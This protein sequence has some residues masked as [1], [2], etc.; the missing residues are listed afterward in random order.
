MVIDAYI[1]SSIKIAVK[2][3]KSINQAC[4]VTTRQLFTYKNPKFLENEKWGYSN[5]NTPPH[6]FSFEIKDDYIHIGRGG[7][8]K[9]EKHLKKFSVTLNI[10]DNTFVGPHIAFNQSKVILRP[11]QEKWLNEFLKYQ[12]GCGQAYTS[13]GKCHSAGTKIVMY[14][15]TTKNVEDIQVGDRLM[16]IDS[17][18]RTVQDTCIGKGEMYEIAPYKSKPFKVNKD[19]ILSLEV[20]RNSRHLSRSTKWTEG[21]IVEY[22]VG[23]YLELSQGMKKMLRLRMVGVEFKEVPIPFDPYFIGLWLGDG[24]KRSTSIANNNEKEIVRY[25]EHFAKSNKLD[26]RVEKNKDKCTIYHLN[27]GGN[28]G[29]RNPLRA[30]LLNKC[31]KEGE[32]TI[33]EEYLIN[34]RKNRLALLAGFLDADGHLVTSDNR[35]FEVTIKKSH[36]VEKIAYLSRSLGFT[37]TE[38]ICKSAYTKNGV[39]VKTGTHTRLFITGK[40]F[41]IP[42]KLKRKRA[43]TKLSSTNLSITGFKI[44]QIPDSL[45]YGFTLDKDKLYLL[46]NFIVNHNTITCCALIKELGQMT[47]I[48]VHTSFLQK[49]WIQE[50]TNKNL[51]NLDP[52]DIGGV[53]GLFSTKKN[54]HETFDKSVPYKSR[55]LGKVNVCLYH[56]VCKPNHLEFFESQ[57]GCLIF[58]EGQKT[59]IEGVQKIVNNFRCRY[60]YSVSAGFKRKDG[61]EFLTFD[62]FGPVRAIAAE[63]ASSSKILS[64]IQL[65][66]STYDDPQYS[67]DG[68]YSNMIT[69]MAKDKTRNILICKLALAKIRQN[70][71]VLIFVERKEHA[72]ILFNMLSNF[73]IDMLLGAVQGKKIKEDPSLSPKVKKILLNYDDITA[74]DRIKRLADKKKLQII[75]GTQKAEVGLSIRTIDHAIV[76]T[77]IGNN[78]ERF[79]QVK[80]RVERTYSQEQEDFFGCLKPRPTIDVLV[81]YKLNVSRNAGNAIKDRYGSDVY[82]MKRKKVI[83]RRKV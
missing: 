56:S 74:Y 48:L 62:S 31:I 46:D 25:I 17:T 13:F 6:L 71:F 53:G 1:E 9:L 34:S 76:T 27:K 65:V 8:E 80:G 68:N 77:P 66:G 19:H 49:Q 30:Y 52:N 75:I 63:K 32:K 18:P 51:F 15:G 43:T 24:A 41:L 12:N 59:P 42:T 69:R 23:E 73:K 70:K 72:A 67:E 58:D 7:L 81:D 26:I 44:K 5:Y 16:G 82:T 57:T 54:F 11:D 22:T 33:P 78:L 21:K 38:K 3:L 83:K 40:T 50:L 2:D 61:K 47:T 10:I 29:K 64:R 35:T 39:K 79:N 4:W 37:V 20:A 45:F 36:L 60:K 28:N 55:K 14:D